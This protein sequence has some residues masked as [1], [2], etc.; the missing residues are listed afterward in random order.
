MKICWRYT[1]TKTL[2]MGN[3]DSYSIFANKNLLSKGIIS[4][5]F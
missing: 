5:Q 1:D 4:H 2:N 3:Y